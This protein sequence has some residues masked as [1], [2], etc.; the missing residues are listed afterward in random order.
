MGFS[1]A[2]AP[3]P[4]LC[5]HVNAT[6]GTGAAPAELRF[7]LPRKPVLTL[8]GLNG[9]EY[10][11]L[12]T[13]YKASHVRLML[14]WLCK[15][16]QQMADQFQHDPELQ[17]LALCCYALQRATEIQTHGGLIL[18]IEEAREASQHVDLFIK[19]FAWLALKCFDDKLLLFKCR[20]KLH[21]MAHVAEDLLRWRLN[22]L[23][24][25]STFTEESFLGRIK[26]IACQVHGKTLTTRV[27]ERYILTLAICLHH[28]KE[29][30][31]LD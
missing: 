30:M 16:S 26:S 23:K 12:S 28:F 15:K 31:A 22:Q 17:V 9:D 25:F 4:G 3:S 10:S 8:A 20:P 27:F 18:E 2:N 1:G 7:Y 13:R 5:R 11:E 19:S 14:F 6:I 29:T 24:M 21:Y